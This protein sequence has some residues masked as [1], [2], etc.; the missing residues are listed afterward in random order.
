MAEASISPLSPAFV[1]LSDVEASAREKLPT[2]VWDYYS[3]GAQDEV[4]VRA[5]RAAYES[6]F[7]RYR[8]LRG[9][10]ERDLSTT[11]LGQKV[12][13]PIL[14]APTAFQG[15]ACAEAELATVCAAGSMGTVMILSML[16]NTA[17]EDVAKASSGPVWLQLYLHKDR[18]A[19]RQLV[20]RAE[21]AGCGALVLTVDSPCFGRQERN[22]RNHFALPRDLLVKNLL[23]RRL[24]RLPSN[25]PELNQSSFEDRLD[26]LL[27]WRDVEW[28]CGLTKLP[29]LVK[30]I[31]RGDDAVLAVQH[32][33]RGVI[34]S[35]H[36]G[37]QLDTAPPTIRVLEE[38][39][40]AVGSSCEVL[41]DGGV[42]RGT[43]VVKALA[44]G[45]RAVLIGRPILWGL[46]VDGENGAR[47]VLEMLSAELNI[48]M[49]LCGCS[50]VSQIGRDLAMAPPEWT[51]A[52]LR[53]G[54]SE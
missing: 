31:I 54:A 38:V 8:V 44:L 52:S 39:T 3:G 22:I 11:V 2:M 7:L 33:V 14:I 28:L 51:G 19:V 17:V 36:G 32:G 20:K 40:G 23:P 26:P 29:V 34:V 13:L 35:N 1:N 16:A 5:N 48:A 42:R 4:T 21:E 41:I 46:S 30:G 37:R 43:D 6:I 47:Q 53:K 49:A 12:S 15:L 10:G 25:W 24:T 9:V 18:G 45:A 27:T 50:S